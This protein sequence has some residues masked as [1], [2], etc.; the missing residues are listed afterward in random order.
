MKVMITLCSACCKLLGVRDNK[1]VVSKCHRKY[2][3]GCGWSSASGLTL[4][5]EELALVKAKELNLLK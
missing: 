4:C 2:C 5:D 3:W 1:D